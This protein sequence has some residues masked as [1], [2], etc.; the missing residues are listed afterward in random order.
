MMKVV[1]R[2][3]LAASF[4]MAMALSV[5]TTQAQKDEQNVNA[6]YDVRGEARF[7]ALAYNHV[8]IV[9]NRCDFPLQCQV[10]TDVDPKPRVSVTVGANSSEERVIRVGSPARGFKAYG[11]CKK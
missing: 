10:W 5:G 8:V 3:L 9:S 6:C 4:A 1:V 11:E 2:S 7:G